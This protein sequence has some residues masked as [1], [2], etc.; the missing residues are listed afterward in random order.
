MSFH[1]V[2]SEHREIEFYCFGPK[3]RE[4][5]WAWS[6]WLG[7]WSGDSFCC[8]L[9]LFHARAMSLAR[10]DQDWGCGDTTSHSWVTSCHF[11]KCLCLQGFLMC[12]MGLMMPPS[13]VLLG[14]CCTTPLEAHSFVKMI[15]VQASEHCRKSVKYMK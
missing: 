1:W 13:D 7:R 9:H 4:K 6:L 14:S 8:E 15:K 5:F 3:T 11:A 2:R 12:K 10:K